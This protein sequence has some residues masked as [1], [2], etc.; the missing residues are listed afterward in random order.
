MEQSVLHNKDQEKHDLSV[1]LL[2]DVNFRE[3][4]PFE[5]RFVVIYRYAL[6]P[7][8]KEVPGLSLDGLKVGLNYRVTWKNEQ[9]QEQTGH[10]LYGLFGFELSRLLEF[11]Y[12]AGLNVGNRLVVGANNLGVTHELICKIRFQLRKK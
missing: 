1:S 9:T 12:I 5:F 7:T 10:N 3:L 6:Y 2:S 4:V 11:N 8:I